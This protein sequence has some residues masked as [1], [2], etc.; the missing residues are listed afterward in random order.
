MEQSDFEKQFCEK[1]SSLYEGQK[2]F[3][4]SKY[5]V[6]LRLAPKH[7]LIMDEIKANN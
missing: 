6:L 1:L 2:V 4:G 7:E 3:V 5:G